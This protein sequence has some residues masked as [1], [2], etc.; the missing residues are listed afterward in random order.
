M[1]DLTG[2]PCGCNSLP[3][4]PG[5]S[6]YLLPCSGRDLLLDGKD[7]LVYNHL[8]EMISDGTKPLELMSLHL[9]KYPKLAEIQWN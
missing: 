8:P 9:S 6:G 3:E 5:I 7:L 1:F 4:N 2:F